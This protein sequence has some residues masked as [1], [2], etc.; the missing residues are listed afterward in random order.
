MSTRN[1]SAPVAVCA[2][3][4]WSCTQ[5]VCCL[6][7]ASV[8]REPFCRFWKLLSLWGCLLSGTLPH[9]GLS[10]PK[11]QPPPSPGLR[12]PSVESSP[13]QEAR[14]DS[15]VSLSSEIRVSAACFS[16]SENS[17]LVCVIQ[18][19]RC[20]PQESKL[21]GGHSFMARS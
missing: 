16:A 1:G 8:T 18:L 4:S 6:V 2:P 7:L 9:P 20:V 11:L 15:S 19:S 21:S 10:F 13:R 17:P 12:P 3:A 5:R 14:A